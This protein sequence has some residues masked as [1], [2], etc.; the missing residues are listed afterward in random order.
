MTTS[1]AKGRS[2]TSSGCSTFLSPANSDLC[3]GLGRRRSTASATCWTCQRFIG[4][5]CRPPHDWSVLT[6]L[7]H[8]YWIR[9]SVSSFW[10]GRPAG[11]RPSSTDSSFCFLAWVPFRRFLLL[12]YENKVFNPPSGKSVPANFCGYACN[13]ITIVY[14][15]RNCWVSSPACHLIW[16]WSSLTSVLDV[17]RGL[18]SW[19]WHLCMPHWSPLLGGDFFRGGPGR[20]S[21]TRPENA[22]CLSMTPPR[23]QTSFSFLLFC[24]VCSSWNSYRRAWFLLTK[25]LSK[26]TVRRSWLAGRSRWSVFVSIFDRAVHLYPFGTVFVCSTLI[27][28]DWLSLWELL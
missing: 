21:F 17:P 25:E 28:S 14:S 20:P 8:R 15:S 11:R 23:C 10:I 4:Y 7:S 5:R 2:W 1:R 13:A 6:C 3:Q 12:H 16:I 27:N 26:E 22:I 19:Y 24:S 9:L 18:L